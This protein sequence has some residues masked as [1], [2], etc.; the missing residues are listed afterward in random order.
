MAVAVWRARGERRHALLGLALA[1]ACAAIPFALWLVASH[2]VFDRSGASATGGLVTHEVN[3]SVTLRGQ[4]SYLWQSFLPRLPWQN[5][6]FPTYPNYL[7]WQ[8]YFQGF[9]GRFGWFQF[10][11]PLWVSEAALPLFAALVALA[12]AALL[13]TRSFLRRRGGEMLTYAALLGG[14]VVAV[15]FAG[16]RAVTVSGEAFEQTRY[17]F[18]LLPLYG[19]LVAVAARGAGRRWGPVVG[20]F[21][22]VLAMGHDLF[23]QLI[24]VARYYA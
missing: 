17:L 18:P 22:V 4:L 6:L 8:T 10:G 21:L 2:E 24:T 13:R 5:D 9:V 12:G 15:S 3:A 16:Y 19:A 7:A 14:L 20:A 1:V 23:A 11:F